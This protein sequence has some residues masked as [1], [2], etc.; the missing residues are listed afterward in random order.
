MLRIEKYA[1]NLCIWAVGSFQLEVRGD[2][3]GDI[4]SIRCDDGDCASFKFFVFSALREDFV[5]V[6]PTR[7]IIVNF[8]YCS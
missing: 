4:D 7:F 1:D 3:E 6:L 8:W 2:G 5:R